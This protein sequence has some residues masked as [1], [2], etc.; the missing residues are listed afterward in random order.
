MSMSDSTTSA[1][2]RKPYPDFPLYAHASGYWAKKISGRT[3]F[4]GP[5]ANHQGALPRYLMQKDD[6][7]AG[8]RPAPPSGAMSPLT[9]KQLVA[10]Y[11]A[12]KKLKVE[13]GDMMVRTLREYK[14]Y[15]MRMIRVFGAQTPVEQLGPSDF[16]ALRKNLQKSHKSLFTLTGPMARV[17]EDNNAIGFGSK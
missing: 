5:W 15:G 12:A 13:C 4:F 9:I 1:K 10:S 7:E 11:L 16:Q 6:L 3:C 14:S 2:P 17:T 8:R